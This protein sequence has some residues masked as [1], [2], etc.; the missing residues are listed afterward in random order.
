MPPVSAVVISPRSRTAQDGVVG[1]ER[2][3]RSI[4]FPPADQKLIRDGFRHF[5][6]VAQYKIAVVLGRGRT[7][8]EETRGQGFQFRLPGLGRWGRGIQG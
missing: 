3:E 4:V 7:A 5:H 6:G 8:G 2:K 1:R